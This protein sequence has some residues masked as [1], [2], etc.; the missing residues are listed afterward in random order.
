MPGKGA[1]EG[2]GKGL[3]GPVSNKNPRPPAYSSPAYQPSP[4][5]EI[6]CRGRGLGWRP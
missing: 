4:A 3:V 2:A 5:G 6:P 1:V